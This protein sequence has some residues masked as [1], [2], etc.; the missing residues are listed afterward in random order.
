MPLIWLYTIASFINK[1]INNYN[2]V[3]S[4]FI[5]TDDIHS[6]WHLIVVIL[7]IDRAGVDTVEKH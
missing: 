2:I 3:F 4:Y 5:Q 1:Y 6:S 7:A